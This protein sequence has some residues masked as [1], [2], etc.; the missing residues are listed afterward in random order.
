MAPLGAAKLEKVLRR[1]LRGL[2][3]DPI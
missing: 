3:A 2:G 1:M